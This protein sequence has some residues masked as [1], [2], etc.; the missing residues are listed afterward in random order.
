MEKAS[1][2]LASV[3]PARVANSD[4][5]ALTRYL[6]AFGLEVSPD[7]LNDL[8]VLLSVV[9]IEVGGSLAL[10]VGMALD[11]SGRPVPATTGQQTSPAGPS[12]PETTSAVPVGA[13]ISVASV[14]PALVSAAL[15]ET[16][17]E[18]FL[19]ASGGTAEGFRRLAGKLGR[20]RST[21]AD[22]CHRLAA[23]GRLMLGRGRRGMTIALGGRTDPADDANDASRAASLI[24]FHVEH[25]GCGARGE[26]P[27]GSPRR[28]CV[29]CRIAPNRGYGS[30]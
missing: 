26:L 22:E 11:T 6:S 5:K 25:G 16:D 20:P 29:A 17:I 4:A 30:T 1:G 21:V 2:A 27:V 12:E 9:M 8:L 7:R 19:R 3:Q 10:A 24:P 15:A 28:G 13:P 14:R 23:A 18:S